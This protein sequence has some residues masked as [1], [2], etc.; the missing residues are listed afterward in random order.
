MAVDGLR[1]GVDVR[2]GGK[3]HLHTSTRRRIERAESGSPARD[4]GRWRNDRPLAFVSCKSRRGAHALLFKEVVSSSRVLSA[5]PQVKTSSE[6]GG[7]AQQSPAQLHRAASRRV[8]EDPD[9][10]TASG[11]SPKHSL[12]SGSCTME[13]SQRSCCLVRRSSSGCIAHGSA[14]LRCTAKREE[15]VQKWRAVHTP[16]AGAR[17]ALPLL[18]HGTPHLQRQREWCQP[19]L[20]TSR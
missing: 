4:G 7:S 13:A 3:E 2:R 6:K 19:P 12:A 5:V 9:T 20:L 14:L 15:G 18:W 10:Y 16:A 11:E 17:G 1:V 8:G